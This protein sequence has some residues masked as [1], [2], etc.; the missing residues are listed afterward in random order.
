MAVA[1][2]NY[3]K[4]GQAIAQ[5]L[6]KIARTESPVCL[7]VLWPVM[8]TS[9]SW[10]LVCEPVCCGESACF[11]E[12]DVCIDVIAC[13]STQRAGRGCMARQRRYAWKG[14]KNLQN[15]QTFQCVFTIQ[16]F[17]EACTEFD[18]GHGANGMER[19]RLLKG[20]SSWSGRVLRDMG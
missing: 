12:R 9:T 8:L 5:L 17:D 11:G 4:N 10:M 3:T 19:V 20:T 16:P 18:E 1:F 6:A 13:D 14:A 7:S 15:R 2:R